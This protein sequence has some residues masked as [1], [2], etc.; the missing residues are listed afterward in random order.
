MN[1]FFTG[2]EP[3]VDIV[4]NTGTTNINA[5]SDD[6]E[7]SISDDLD[8]QTGT[9]TARVE[10]DSFESYEFGNKPQVFVNGIGG[11]DQYDVDLAFP[12]DGLNLLRLDGGQ[13]SAGSDHVVINGQASDDLLVASNLH[14][15]GGDF[16][17]TLD[18]PGNDFGP[19]VLPTIE[20]DAI[21]L[22]IFNGGTGVDDLRVE[23]SGD[24]ERFVHT[25][26]TASPD[27]GRI[28]S[29]NETLDEQYIPIE[30]LSTVANPPNFTVIVDGSGG[31]DTLVA[32]G[33]ADDDEVD[34]DFTDLDGG[35]TDNDILIDL[36]SNLG[37]HVQ[38]Q[39]EG[40]ESFEIRAQAGNDDINVQGDVGA[41]ISFAV[42]GNES[43]A[44]TDRLDISL[45]AAAGAQIVGITQDFVNSDEQDITGVGTLIDVQG[46]ELIGLIGGGGDDALE[47]NLGAGDNTAT[48]ERADVLAFPTDLLT[49]DSL[50]NI[51]FT[52]LDRFRA[53]GGS[54]SDVVTF[55]TCSWAEHCRGITNSTE[56][57]P[58]H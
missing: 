35:G 13:P 57:A 6:N 4:N 5:T 48:V 40:V 19:L 2:L 28:D 56:P 26:S 21:E 29:F 7:I 12:P 25:P 24:D 51:E 45:D 36:S 49:S 53:I 18:A 55:K 3:I 8:G 44:G 46:I 58:T 23:G 31:N 38:L 41:D 34:V 9:F 10:I 47:A 42:F 22:A 16:N 15:S 50:P 39:S 14:S 37:D 30:Y 43:D 20:L 32:K 17:L 54:G 11:S 52:D 33:T 27:A 1:L